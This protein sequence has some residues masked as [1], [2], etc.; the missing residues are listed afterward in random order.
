MN[1]DWFVWHKP[2]IHGGLTFLLSQSSRSG[3]KTGAPNSASRSA[4]LQRP[5]QQPRTAPG[6]S[7]TPETTTAKTPNPPTRTAQ[8]DRARTRCPPPTAADRAPPESRW[9]TPP[10]TDRW[11]RWRPPCPA[12][13]GW[14]QRAKA[15]PPPRGPS[16]RSRTLWAGRSPAYCRLCKDRTEPKLH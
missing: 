14:Q 16:P 3:S 10:G 7:P 4:Q 12:A 15:G 11:T 13:W 1:S 8:E 2:I 6:R 9:S 5:Q